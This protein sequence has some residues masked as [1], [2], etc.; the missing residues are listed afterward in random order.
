MWCR[1]PGRR[2]G[3]SW[4]GGRGCCGLCRSEWWC[5]GRVA[6][7]DLGVARAG[8]GAGRGGGEGG[9]GHVRVRPG[10]RHLGGLGQVAQAAGGG[11]AVHPGTAGV[12]AGRA[13]WPAGRGSGTRT[14]LVPVPQPRAT[15]W[16]CSPPGGRRCPRRWLRRSARPSR[17]SMATRPKPPG[18]ADFRAAV[19][20][21]LRI[22]GGGT[23]G[24]VT[25]AGPGASGRARPVR[26][27][28]GRLLTPV[29]QNPCRG[30]KRRESADGLDGRICCSHPMSSSGCGRPAARGPGPR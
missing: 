30:R 24:W 15:R 29:L 2:P 8:A 27:P 11:V 9:A 7:G 22:A 6:G 14:M 10:G 16:P 19:T 20:Q 18:L 21:R 26:A 25:A 1:R 5:V 28:A 13:A 23:P 12:Q 3:C 17:H 4:G